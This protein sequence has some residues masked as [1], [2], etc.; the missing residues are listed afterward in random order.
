MHTACKGLNVTNDK[1]S[2]SYKLNTAIQLNKLQ[3]IKHI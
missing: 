2:R 1:R 3:I